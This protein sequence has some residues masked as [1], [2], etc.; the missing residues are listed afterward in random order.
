MRQFQTETKGRRSSHPR[1][2][3]VAYAE[4]IAR[5]GPRESHSLLRTFPSLTACILTVLVGGLF[6]LVLVWTQNPTPLAG[7]ISVFWV[8]VALL[9]LAIAAVVEVEVPGSQPKAR[10]TKA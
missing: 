5:A 2:E 1:G 8:I 10:K 4:T 6:V 7:S 3:E 9:G